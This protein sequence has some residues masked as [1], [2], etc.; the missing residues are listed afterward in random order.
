MAEH[1]QINKIPELM[2]VPE[3]IV[4]TRLKSAKV[5]GYNPSASYKFYYEHKSHSE[6]PHVI[7]FSGGRSSGMLLVILLENKIL[8][9]ERGDVV[10]FNNTSAEHASTYDF[11]AECK[12]LTES[13][14][15]PFFWIEFQTY[16]DAIRGEWTRMPT[17][18]LVNA[19][20]YSAQNPNGYK[21]KG[22]VFEELLSLQSFVPN[23]H[24][25]T[26]TSMMKVRATRNFLKDWFAVK[27]EIGRCG[28]YY[29]KSMVNRDTIEKAHRQNGGK[30]PIEILMKKREF[31]ISCVPHRPAQKF[32]DFTDVEININNPM[33]NGRRAGGRALLSGDNAVE[34]LSFVGLRADEPHRIGRMIK[35]NRQDDEGDGDDG[36]HLYAPL[37]AMGVCK[38]NIY[39]FWEA[40]SWGLDLPYDKNLSNCVYCFLKGSKNLVNIA[41]NESPQDDAVL[42]PANIRWWKDM[43]KKYGRNLR[44]EGRDIKTKTEDSVIGFFGLNSS[45]SYDKIAQ[46]AKSDTRIDG[47][48]DTESLPCDCT[49]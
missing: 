46:R 25:R 38:Q 16:E 43:E 9:P 3:L 29:E 48:M 23:Q 36:E 44:E 1:K 11:A 37:S 24:R 14:G 10:V 5:P 27:S 31:L 39:D 33:L 47:D 2:Q 19:E 12:K 45:I 15:V 26:C 40:Q 8:K 42:T 20:P 32:S 18:R 13:Y 22:E 28:H 21:H 49:D 35:R 34:Y 30:T 7:K 17:Y 4:Q 6:T 41:Q